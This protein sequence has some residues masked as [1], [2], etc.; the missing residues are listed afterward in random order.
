MPAD[1]IQW[2]PDQPDTN[3]A[4][5]NIQTTLSPAPELRRAAADQPR[6]AKPSE[7]YQTPAQFRRGTSPDRVQLSA[8]SER[9][10]SSGNIAATSPSNNPHFGGAC[11]SQIAVA[12]YA[13]QSDQA[14]LAV[15]T[16]CPPS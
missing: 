16:I 2:H 11:H 10:Y 3:S 7:Y 8:H 13:R 9:Q 12:M 1:R 14:R 4:G 6:S 5:Y 15:S